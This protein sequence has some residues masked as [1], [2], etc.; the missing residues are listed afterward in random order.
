M[1]KNTKL[2]YSRPSLTKVGIPFPG[3]TPVD[4]RDIYRLILEMS[5]QD[6]SIIQPECP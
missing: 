2:D 5:W 1:K 6:I 3:V 4:S